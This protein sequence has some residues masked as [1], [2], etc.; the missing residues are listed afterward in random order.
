[1]DPFGDHRLVPDAARPHP[2]LT[3]RTSRPGF[4]DLDARERSPMTA[5]EIH[6][7]RLS[8]LVRA[9]PP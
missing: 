8:G 2:G 3:R 9:G 6:G 5:K 7:T 4:Y 1:M